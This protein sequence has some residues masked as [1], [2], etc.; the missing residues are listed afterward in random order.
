MEERPGNEPGERGWSRL[1]SSLVALVCII[2]VAGGIGIA[3]SL[4][5]QRPAGVRP[6]STAVLP[7][8]RVTPSTG[9]DGPSSGAL[10]SVA[11]DVATH[12]IV[13]VGGLGNYA[14]TWLW[15]G[16]RWTQA[17]PATRPPGRFGASAAY[18]PA[19]STVLL[20]GGRTEPGTPIHDTWGWNGTDWTALDSGAGGPKPGTGSDMAWDDTLHEMVLTTESGVLGEPANTWIWAGTHWRHPAGAHLPAGAFYTPMWFDPKTKSLL[21]V[22]CCE[23]PPPSTGAVNTTWR[24]DGSTWT[25]VPTPNQSPIRA[26]TMALDPATGSLVLCS[27]G[28]SVPPQ[29]E[30]LRWDG[31]AWGSIAAGRPPVQL[32]VEVTDFG[33]GQ[34]LLLGSPLA[35]MQAGPLPVQ[36]WALTGSTWRRID[37]ANT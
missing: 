20:F 34:L 5:R 27:C 10:F 16:I 15:N 33:R 21:A 26:S 8:L 36:V 35:D 14:N 17:H 22:G 11:D 6:S 24:W 2:A 31:S 1:S 9:T 37:R 32:G 30:L 23:G 3:V 13:L 18:D 29:P 12:D 28:S 19:T 7:S 25:L 4:S